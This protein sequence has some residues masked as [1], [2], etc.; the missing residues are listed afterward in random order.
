MLEAI[1]SIDEEASSAAE[2]CS[3]APC[4][5]CSEAAESCCEPEETLSEADI[6]SFTTARSRSTMRSRAWPSVSLSESGFGVTIR[7][8]SAISVAMSAVLERLAVIRSI[9][10]IR[11][12]I[13]SLDLWTTCLERSPMATASASST[14]RFRPLEIDSDIHRATPTAK[15]KTR[16]VAASSWRRVSS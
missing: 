7:L 4:A 10:V 16:P 15:R 5:I 1:S 8:P 3:D 12:L 9:A 11:S 2:A 6:A 14:P 13:S